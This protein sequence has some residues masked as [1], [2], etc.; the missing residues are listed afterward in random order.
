[1]LTPGK[2]RPTGGNGGAGGDVYIIA[3]RNTS[4]LNLQTAHFNAG[5][6]GNGGSN[7]CDIVW[8]FLTFRLEDGMKGARGKDTFIKVPCGT[9]VTEKVNNGMFQKMVCSLIPIV[10][11]SALT[12]LLCVITE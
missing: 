1:M 11:S 9:I 4:S 3:D 8:I 7:F 12:L 10:Q 5:S 6:G 2:K